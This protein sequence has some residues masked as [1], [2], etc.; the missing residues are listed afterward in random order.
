MSRGNARQKIFRD[1]RDYGRFLE[2]LET[3]V[4]KFGFEIF[5]WLRGVRP[6]FRV[7][8]ERKEA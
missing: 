3:T 1:E 8:W 7:F 4:D 2:G 6:V 5:R